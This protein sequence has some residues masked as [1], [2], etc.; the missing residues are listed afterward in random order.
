MQGVDSCM[1]IIKKLGITTGELVVRNK[2]DDSGDREYK[3]YDI[4][5]HYPWG[6]RGI[7]YEMENP[8][9]ARL[10]CAAPEMLEALIFQLKAFEN[11]VKGEKQNWETNVFDLLNKSWIQQ[12]KAVE[13]ATGLS[14]EEIKAIL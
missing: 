7:V 12:K 11:I 6:D 3:T 9:E 10:F 5:S 1:N 14:W 8:S 4:L 2:V 13:K